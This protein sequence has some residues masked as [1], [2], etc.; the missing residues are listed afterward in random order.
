[1]ST[2]VIAERYPADKQ[3]ADIVDSLISSDEQAKQLGRMYI[4]SNSTNR[5]IV[6]GSS[7]ISAYME[8]G[9]IVQVIDIQ[10]GRYNG[11]LNNYSASITKQSDGKF[12]AVTSISI[13]KEV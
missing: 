9:G 8:P 13:E 3:G 1:M 6:S 11:M 10:K 7:P 5:F 2:S 4:D 12:T